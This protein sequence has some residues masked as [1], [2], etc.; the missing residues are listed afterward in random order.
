VDK[1]TTRALQAQ[2]EAANVDR[3]NSNS[4]KKEQGK[5]EVA[6][7]Q[8]QTRRTEADANAY[9]VVAAARADAEA[10]EIAAQAQANAT[11][12]GAEAEADAIRSRATADSGVDDAFAREMSARRVEVNRVQAFGNRTVFVPTDASTGGG[13]SS[14]LAMG[15]GM[16]QGI[17]QSK[18]TKTK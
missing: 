1:L 15:M 18:E 11:R 5:L 4:V 17:S 3:E 10:T 16:A 6:R 2:V 14:A 12:L 13:I 8:A 9:S 7:V